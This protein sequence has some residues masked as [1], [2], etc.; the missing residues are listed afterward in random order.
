VAEE[1]QMPI[2]QA[3]KQVVAWL[4]QKNEYVLAI[5]ETKDYML[6]YNPGIDVGIFAQHPFYTFHLYR[7]D[8]LENLHRVIT[9]LSL[10][11]SADIGDLQVS[12]KAA[13]ELQVAEGAP[14]PKPVTPVVD[15]APP[16]EEEEDHSSLHLETGMSKSLIL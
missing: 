12:A 6:Q 14:A 13:K 16:E 7:V 5:P 1:F 15:E 4:A 10:M 2:D 8:S 11:I 3:R 9:V